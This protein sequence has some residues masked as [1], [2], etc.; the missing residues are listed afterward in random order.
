MWL[1]FTLLRPALNYKGQVYVMTLVHLL[2]VMPQVFV[3]V[4]LFRDG[5]VTRMGPNPGHWPIEKT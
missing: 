3:T 1:F 4:T 5:E 2:M